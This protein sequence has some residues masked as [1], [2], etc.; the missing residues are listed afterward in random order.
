MP[1]LRPK[2]AFPR[3]PT[4]AA[5]KALLLA[6][7]VLAVP[8]SARGNMASPVHP[9]ARVGEPA[10]GLEHLVVVHESL[11]IDLRALAKGDPAV[12]QAVYRVRNDGARRTVPLLFVADG[13]LDEGSGVWM[14]GLP[15]PSLPA[16]AAGLPAS[17]QPPAHTPALEPGLPALDYDVADRAGDL[18]F[19]LDLAP[20]EHVVRVRYLARATARSGDSPAVF[21]Q[22]GYVLA[23]ARDWAGF[24]GMDLRVDL[25]AGWRAASSP[26]LRRQGD[27]LVGAWNRLP[28]DALALT[29]QA[30]VGSGA[31]TRAGFV[32]LVLAGLVVCAWLGRLLGA[33]LA[34]RGRSTG[35]ATAP[36]AALALVWSV[37]AGI[38]GAALPSLLTG[39]LGPQKAWGYGYGTAVFALLAVPVLF[40]LCLAVTQTAAW[41]GARAVRRAPSAALP[42]DSDLSPPQGAAS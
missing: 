32:A 30:P 33:A 41:L 20:G 2:I 34:R 29:A 24:G 8:A 7:A 11:R 39:S 27:A 14:D 4:S 19:A 38:G 40:V 21:W 36:S 26:A 17:W 28:A 6:A 12:V 22:L 5:V 18:S 3:P 16:K 35:W 25:P 13:L 10:S 23:P 1:I 31:G 15:V 42:V 9:G 37:A